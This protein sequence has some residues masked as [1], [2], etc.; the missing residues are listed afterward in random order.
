MIHRFAFV[1]LLV[2]GG[3]ASEVDSVYDTFDDSREVACT[4]HEELAFE[5]QAACERELL[6][7]I[8]ATDAQR[9]CLEDVYDRLE[10]SR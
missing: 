8:A 10:G 5:T 4:C 1:P 9:A 6:A 3:C 7:D 2:L